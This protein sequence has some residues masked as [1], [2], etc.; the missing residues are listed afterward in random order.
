MLKTVGSTVAARIVEILGP[1][2]IF[3]ARPTVF[4]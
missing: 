2:S 3:V 4:A 1:S